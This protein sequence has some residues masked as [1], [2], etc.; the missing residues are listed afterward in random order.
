MD[1]LAEGKDTDLS[2]HYSP[3]R[4]QAIVN[5]FMGLGFFIGFLI[6][7][8]ILA[9]GIYALVEGLSLKDL[10]DPSNMSSINNSTTGLRILNLFSSALPLILAAWL[11]TRIGFKG[12]MEALYGKSLKINRYFAL[13]LLF[14]AAVIPL[15]GVLVELNAKLDV[16]FISE[17]LQKWIVSAEDQN[18]GL[19]EVIA[20]KGTTADLLINLLLMAALP[21]LAEEFFFRGLLLNIF[22]SWF[23]NPHLGIWI[24]AIVF[25]A[26]HMQ[27]LKILPMICL[28]A[29]FGYLVYWNGSIWPAVLAH[30]VNNALAVVALQM[31]S[32]DYTE[33]LSQQSDIP[34][35]AIVVLVAAV[36]I[37]FAYLQKNAE[38]KLRDPYA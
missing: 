1:T 36:I 32:G 23:R 30:F 2:T 37:L 20:G 24:S 21:A 16:S 3:G 34:T 15:V 29:A 18:N 25:G 6:L 13:S 4:G 31:N 10:M 33:V 12:K 14:L 8:S 26:I 28:G 9:V 7:F 17:S 22:R 35:I 38:P 5:F 27:F 11:T 19:Y